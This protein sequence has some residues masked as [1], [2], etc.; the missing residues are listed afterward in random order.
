MAHKFAI[1]RL[2]ANIGHVGALLFTHFA[3]R[4]L[5]ARRGV[6][7]LTDGFYNISPRHELACWSSS[8]TSGITID[9]IRGLSSLKD[10]L[11]RRIFTRRR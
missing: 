2:S 6:V 10:S 9:D 5:G 11:Q 1:W 4:E 7:A 3:M 8:V